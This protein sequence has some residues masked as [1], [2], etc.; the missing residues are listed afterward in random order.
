MN[1]Y[2]KKVERDNI[3]FIDKQNNIFSNYNES[4]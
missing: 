2:I 1:N 4:R 3:V